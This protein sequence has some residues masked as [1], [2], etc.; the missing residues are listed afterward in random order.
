MAATL[1][2]LH[3]VV[4]PPPHGQNRTSRVALPLDKQWTINRPTRV[5]TRHGNGGQRI[6]ALVVTASFVPFVP[7]PF[8]LSLGVTEIQLTFPLVGGNRRRAVL[9]YEGLHHANSCFEANRAVVGSDS[10]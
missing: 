3:G 8:N 6:D 7:S 4:D 10:D 2:L 5:F 1:S 9:F